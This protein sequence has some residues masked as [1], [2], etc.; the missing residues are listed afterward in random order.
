MTPAT[1][2]TATDGYQFH[3][4][5]ALFSYSGYLADGIGVVSLLQGNFTQ[6]ADGTV[7]ARVSY[8]AHS[9]HAD[10]FPPK[11]AAHVKRYDP[12]NAFILS[13]MGDDGQATI[14]EIKGEDVVGVTPE[15]LWRRE[16]SN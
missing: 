8:I 15:E 6:H 14:L 12:C 3:R 13:I 11:L 16:M 4:H 7:E 9:K 1:H 10:T 5:L 2:I